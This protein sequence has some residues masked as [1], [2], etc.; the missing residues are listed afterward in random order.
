MTPATASDPGVVRLS[1]AQN[2]YER[3]QAAS[4]KDTLPFDQ[5]IGT[6]CLSEEVQKVSSYQTR[7]LATKVE[8]PSGHMFVN[9][10]YYPFA[11]VSKTDNCCL[12]DSTGP[13]SSRVN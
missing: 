7:L 9:G 5:V 10:K 6:S 13:I 2:A 11:N 8:S 3:L 1:L 4:P 12:L